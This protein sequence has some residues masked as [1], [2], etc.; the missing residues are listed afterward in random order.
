MNLLVLTTLY[1]STVR[2]RHGIFV[3]SRLLQLQRYRDVHARVI[4][5]VPWFPSS[6][7]CF[8]EYAL[9][10]RTPR[11][12][13]R[14]GN[15]VG[16]PRYL[17]IPRVGMYIQPFAIA[18]TVISQ[19]KRWGREGFEYDLIDAHYFYPDGVAAALVAKALGRPLII[20]ARGTDVNLIG[21]FGLARKW[22][23]RSA[24]QAE[25]VI[26]VSAALRD[27]L[28]S[29][30]LEPKHIT[31]L[32]NG[33]DL[34]IFEPVPKQTA[35]RAIGIPD[36]QLIVMVGNLVPEKGHDLVLTALTE[37]PGIYLAIVGEGPERRNL[38]NLIDKYGLRDRVRFLAVR[39]Q[40]E[41]K[42]VYSAADVL[43][44]ASTREGWPNVL[45]EA[46]ACGTP[47]VATD[48]GGVREIVTDHC[49]GRVV[50]RRD[51]KELAHCVRAVLEEKHSPD[52]TR[53]FAERFGW[54]ETSE[55]Q[56]K[57]F[58]LALDS[59]ARRTAGQRGTSK[60]LDKSR[61]GDQ[62]H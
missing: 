56:M 17:M 4:A 12:E 55:G 45:L 6:A 37:L 54:D 39:P 23:L 61:A 31:V 43:V 27:K 29:L 14:S 38:D 60:Q 26:T 25:A 48:V 46:M 59:F 32:R 22:I 7:K 20:T 16:H 57:I 53:R 3:E 51:A 9:F 21:G 62:R 35:R 18:T 34:K 50:E 58:E 41:L 10:A 40:S 19:I 36:R 52:Q 28:V 42:W 15:L 2:P 11:W 1:P 33:V 24:C 30:G 44:L 47:V 8:G 5:P 13:M 49:A